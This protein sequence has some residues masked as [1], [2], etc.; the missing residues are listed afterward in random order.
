MIA[1]ILF[2][3]F[4][5]LDD[6]FK[7]IRCYS[8]CCQNSECSC[9]NVEIESEDKKEEEDIQ[10]VIEQTLHQ[11]HHTHHHTHETEEKDNEM[12]AM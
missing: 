7:N 4:Q 10:V 11:H 8:R 1:K 6:T 3:I 5:F 12:K 2:V 9:T